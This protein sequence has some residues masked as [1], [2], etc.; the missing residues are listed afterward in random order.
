M[1]CF[2]ELL[3]GDRTDKGACIHLSRVHIELLRIR[4]FLLFSFQNG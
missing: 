1:L 3:G 4:R 2:L